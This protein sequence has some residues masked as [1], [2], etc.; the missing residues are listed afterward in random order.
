MY[1]C[2]LNK[3]GQLGL[4][5]NKSKTGFTHINCFAGINIQKFMAGGNHTWFQ[6][7]E[8][9]PK[10]INYTFPLPLKSLLDAEKK[11]KDRSVSPALNKSKISEKRKKESSANPGQKFADTNLPEVERNEQNKVLSNQQIV[12]KILNL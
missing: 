1:A 3:D 10:K 12:E 4:G 8:F 2:G 6:V 5:N 11:K 9:C 7:D